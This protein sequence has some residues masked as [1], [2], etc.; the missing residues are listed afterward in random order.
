MPPPLTRIVPPIAAGLAIAGVIY[1]LIAVLDGDVKKIMLSEYRQGT[2]SYIVQ[3][4]NGK[5]AELIIEGPFMM[6]GGTFRKG[7]E[8]M[9]VKG[10]FYL[11]K[12]AVFEHGGGLLIIEGD[13]KLHVEK[14]PGKV[15]IIPAVYGP[16]YS[17]TGAVLFGT[18]EV[19][20]ATGS[21]TEYF[22][23]SIGRVLIR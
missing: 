14:K 16:R 9:T 19:V 8:P 3:D 13:V 5:D 20:T 11:G 4:G 1:V 23:P 10:D 15:T 17:E 12:D 18:G 21:T 22:T 6:T 7:K 2:G